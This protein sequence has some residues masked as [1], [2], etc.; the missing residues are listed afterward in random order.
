MAV[1]DQIDGELGG[2]GLTVWMWQLKK[3]LADDGHL[4]TVDSSIPADVNDS[5]NIL[6]TSSAK[7]YFG[8]DLSGHIKTQLG[9]TADQIKAMYIA[10]SL[11]TASETGLI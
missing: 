7:S 10:A 6:W 1:V 4:K 11:Q 3:Q 5:I 2:M 8:D 9:T